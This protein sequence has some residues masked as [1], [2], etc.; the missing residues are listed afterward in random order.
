MTSSPGPGRGEPGWA[1][2]QACWVSTIGRPVL[3]FDQISVCSEISKASSTSIP[4]YRTVDSNRR[5]ASRRGLE[6][7]VSATSRRSG[8]SPN[9]TRGRSRQRTEGAGAVGPAAD[10]TQ[11]SRSFSSKGVR[12]RV[13][14]TR[15]GLRCYRLLHA[16][17][18][19]ESPDKENDNGADDCADEPGTLAGRIPSKRL[20]EIARNDRSHDAEDRRQHETRGLV[21]CP[22]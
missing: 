6:F 14:S 18:G 13:G 10:P 21:A 15:I 2:R 17:L 22:A 19:D 16:P 20:P 12:T 3:R 1:A 5:A 4:R 8:S 7:A 9:P 11:A